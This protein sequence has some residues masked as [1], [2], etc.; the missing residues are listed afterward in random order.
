MWLAFIQ[1]RQEVLEVAHLFDAM[2]D[3]GFA[4]RTRPN[5][6]GQQLSHGGGF[7]WHIHDMDQ[8]HPTWHRLQFVVQMADGDA[9]F[10]PRR[11]NRLRPDLVDAHRRIGVE[12]GVAAEVLFELGDRTLAGFSRP[13]HQQARSTWS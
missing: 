5:P 6:F 10:E 7:P 9:V 1:L 4:H 12:A 3:P 2:A 13:V 8:A 11:D